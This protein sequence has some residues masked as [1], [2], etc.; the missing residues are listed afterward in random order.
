[1]AKKKI[2]LF[3]TLVGALSLGAVALLG[4]N[5]KDL[6]RLTATQYVLEF[7][8]EKNGFNDLMANELQAFTSSKNAIKVSAEPAV[9]VTAF[10][11]GAFTVAAGTY[12]QN[13][14]P[15]TGIQSV[16]V[17]TA[18]GETLSCSLG[19][20]EGTEINWVETVIL[21]D[22]KSFDFNMTQ[23]SHLRFINDNEEAVSINSF[24]VSYSCEAQDN[25]VELKG[26]FNEW[27]AGTK[28][29]YNYSYE[30][31]SY[32]DQWMIKG[33]ELKAGTEFKFHEPAK[34]DSG[35]FGYEVLGLGEGSAAAVGQ[36]VSGENGNLKAAF[37][38]TVDMYFK[39]NRDGGTYSAWIGQDPNGE[40]AEV[41][42][43]E[44]YK[45]YCVTPGWETVNVHMLGG[46]AAGTSWPG[47]AATK[48]ESVE[49]AWYVE[50]PE[51]A[52]KNIIFNNGDSQTG[53]LTIPGKDDTNNCYWIKEGKWTTLEAA[54]AEPEE[55]SE[56]EEPAADTY[57]IYVVVPDGWSDVKIYGWGGTNSKAWPGTAMT[58]YTDKE[59]T[60]VY[61]AKEGEF[62]SI[63]FNGGG[64]Q[65]ADLKC[66]AKDAE[67][68]CYYVEAKD[69]GTLEAAPGEYVPELSPIYLI[70][71]TYGNAYFYA[72][73]DGCG[74]NGWPGE[75]MTKE[76]D[77]FVYQLDLKIGYEN[78]I[79][80]NNSGSQTADLTLPTD[81]KNC[82]D[83][84]TNTWT[85]YTA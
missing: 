31:L 13:D 19:Y 55:P 22:E 2:I 10:E 7:S 73:G 4:Y 9:G 57:P 76:G 64:K 32:E 16:L 77:V 45:V 81:G 53:D 50:V 39:Y 72:W 66:P 59:N 71:C 60:W 24:K 14:T 27:G 63:I 62:G 17:D 46:T 58:S 51:G 48:H 74:N 44:T 42:E 49:N 43:V 18:N 69:W 75:K 70:N 78:C 85:T 38:I 33:V 1:M 79:F 34:G 11:D 67:L 5:V 82:Y 15:I 84:S 28:M 83:M 30:N 6:Q 8:A 80:N 37:D 20:V 23:P 21:A 61:Y 29:Y 36:I 26:S 47:V 35:W 3:S 25:I 54:S 68:N 56:P 65:T 40:T 12:F 52:Y 41:P